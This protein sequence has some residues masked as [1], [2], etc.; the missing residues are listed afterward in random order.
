M[1]I[2]IGR[3]ARTAGLMMA[4]FLLMTTVG[5]KSKPREQPGGSSGPRAVESPLPPPTLNDVTAKV[6]SIYKGALHVD[7]QRKPV[8]VLGDF[9]ADK[10]EDVVVA[11]RPDRN[12]LADLNSEVAA[13]IVEDPHLIWVPDP[14]K[15]V[16]ALPAKTRPARVRDGERL[17]VIIHGFKEK[18]WRNPLATQSY[19]LVN[20][21]GHGLRKETIKESAAELD[22]ARLPVGMEYL[23]RYNGEVLRETLAGT[24]GILYWT[25]G[26][27]AWTDHLRRT[28]RS[29]DRFSRTAA[30][31]HAR[32][33]FSPSGK[34]ANR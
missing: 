5:C 14:N 4:G 11:V 30:V 29:P 12:R 31:L 17:L 20:A 16:Q 9:N 26:H 24:P 3:A 15:A 6:E 2:A 32:G 23:L 19:L 34:V 21:D 28:H 27:Y 8:F 1:E 18:G 13:W 25:G 7:T 22:Q 10:S 33:R